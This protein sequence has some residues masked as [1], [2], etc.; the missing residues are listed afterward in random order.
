MATTIREIY[1]DYGEGEGQKRRARVRSQ[2]PNHHG[3]QTHRYH[4]SME[5]DDINMLLNCWRRRV[6]GEPWYRINW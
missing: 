2:A 6:N 5:P 4:A 3:G 1:G